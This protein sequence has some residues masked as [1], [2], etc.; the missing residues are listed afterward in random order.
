MRTKRV[1]WR[2]GRVVS[3]ELPGGVFTLAQMLLDPY[4][5]FYHFFPD[6]AAS[7][8]AGRVDV[9]APLFCVSVVNE[10]LKTYCEAAPHTAADVPEVPRRWIRPIMRGGVGFRGGDL[11]EF[12]PR[13]GRT[14]A[15]EPVIADLN[16]A[17]HRDVI[18]AH[19][20]T[21]MRGGAELAARLAMCRVYGRNVDPL[22]ATVFGF[23]YDA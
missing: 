17:R 11:I 20:L 23:R 13:V 18:D 6:D 10:F 4:L 9:L 14:G 7:A 22:K 3:V 5:Q 21:N 8:R 1:V 12:D 15:E 16:A 2:P 19:E